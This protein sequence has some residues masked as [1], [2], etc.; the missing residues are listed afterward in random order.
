MNDTAS[1]SI[2]ETDRLVIREL[3]EDDAE[4]VHRLL[5][6]PNFK[7]YIGD[8]NV[9]SDEDARVFIRDRYRKSYE[10]HGYGLYAVEL[11]A[12]GTPIGMCGFVRRDTLPAPDLGFAFLP[13]HE[14][15]G[16][17]SE[18]SIAVVNYGRKTFGFSE[19]LAITTVDN[20]A[21][22]AL[23]KKI[24]FEFDSVIDTPEGERLNLFRLTLDGN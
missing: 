6:S 14:R 1:T 19:L 21:S 15:K 12:D 8:R 16:Y 22:V 11:R 4:F 23:L 18:S 3:V 2:V 7:R 13:E 9:R 5:N 10:L 20:D 24:G 17:G